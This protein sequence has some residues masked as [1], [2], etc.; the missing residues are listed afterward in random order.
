MT[1]QQKSADK[2]DILLDL[3]NILCKE[4]LK[5]KRLH[6]MIPLIMLKKLTL[7]GATVW[8]G[9]AFTRELSS[10]H[11]RAPSS[12][13][14]FFPFPFLSFCP[15]LPPP[16][17][18]LLCSGGLRQVP[19]N[20][21]SPDSNS[22]CGPVLDHRHVPLCSFFCD[23]SD[24]SF[25]LVFVAVAVILR[26]DLTLPRWPPSP[27]STFLTAT[28][29]ILGQETTQLYTFLTCYLFYIQIENVLYQ[30]KIMSL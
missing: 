20:E 15:S 8:R 2:F 28:L 30:Q 1:Q 13:P 10:K 23:C 14:I 11:T 18:S 16:L 7:Y 22:F 24:F 17:P 9:G 21:S 4:T 5:P 25:P 6:D 3:K 29:H 19:S 26:R 27:K 12:F